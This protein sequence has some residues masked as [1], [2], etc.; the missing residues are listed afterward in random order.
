MFQLRHSDWVEE[1]VLEALGGGGSE[2]WVELDHRHQKRGHVFVFLSDLFFECLVLFFV[3][4]LHGA[5][6]FGVLVHDEAE[7]IVIH[8]SKF[9]YDTFYLVFV[10]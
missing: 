8:R 5:V 7:V 6:G 9:V 10:A 4:L 2:E 1:G 3:R